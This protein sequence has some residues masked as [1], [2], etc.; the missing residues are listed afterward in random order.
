VTYTIKA[1]GA[2]PTIKANRDWFNENSAFAPSTTHSSTITTGVGYG[3]LANLP[4][5]CTPGIDGAQPQT[6]TGNAPGVGYWAT[7][8]GPDGTLYV[9]TATDTWT[10]Y[11][12]PFIYPHPLTGA[13][14]GK[15]IQ[16]TG[17][18]AFGNVI[19]G[20][21]AQLVLT[22][23]NQGDA[24]LTV[25]SISYPTGYSGAWRHNCGPAPATM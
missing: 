23:W 13:G 5:H 10:L 15:I 16:L 4:D 24:T 14:G 19:T 1:Q 3:T 2:P 21:T 18:M 7:N 9:C 20:T 12:R 25:S 8:D 22:I 17:N 11:Y 6:G